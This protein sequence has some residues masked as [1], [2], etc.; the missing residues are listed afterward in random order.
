MILAET[1]ASPGFGV[2]VV[3]LAASE[4]VASPTRNTRNTSGM[5]IK[6]N[7]YPIPPLSVTNRGEILVTI[8]STWFGLCG[9]VGG[10]CGDGGEGRDR[11]WVMCAGRK[12]P[13]LQLGCLF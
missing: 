7:R 4:L 6:S 8:T 1:A 11:W 2:A 5:Y 10:V 3:E 13:A 9:V 12:T